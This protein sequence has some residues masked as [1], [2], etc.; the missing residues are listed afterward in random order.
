MSTLSYLLLTI[1][2]CSTCLRSS[3]IYN[4]ATILQGKYYA[5]TIFY[6]CL[7]QCGSESSYAIQK[8][9]TCNDGAA[10]RQKRP[11]SLQPLWSRAATIPALTNYPGT[12]MWGREI[13][14]TWFKPLVVWHLFYIRLIIYS[15]ANVDPAQNCNLNHLEKRKIL[16]FK[17]KKKTKKK[18]KIPVE[19]LW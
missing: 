8:R 11:G 14:S 1:A 18:K 3:H 2:S 15:P 13:C 17:Q 10:I 19:L 9:V 5:H 16:I 4:F 6:P 7:E 12:I